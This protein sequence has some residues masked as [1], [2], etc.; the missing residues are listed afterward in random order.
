MRFIQFSIVC[1][2]SIAAFSQ[3]RV[4]ASLP[5]NVSYYGGLLLNPGLSIGTDYDL[6]EKLKI[7]EKKRK[8]VSIKKGYALTPQISFYSQ[9]QSQ[10]NLISSIALTKKRTRNN[11]RFREFGISLGHTQKFNSGETLVVGSNGV[12]SGKAI[13]SRAYFTPGVSLG[14]GRYF[15]I[16]DAEPI[17]LYSKLNA[18]QFLGYNSAWVPEFNFEIG[19]RFYPGITINRKPVKSKVKA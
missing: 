1:L 16:K 13:S 14:C 5:I 17:A 7:K 4:E 8:K 15:N 6:T 10:V 3:D 9:T 11:K 18:L 2:L 12:V 19:V